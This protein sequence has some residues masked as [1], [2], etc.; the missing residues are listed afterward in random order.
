MAARYG[1]DNID[2]LRGDIL[3]LPKLGRSFDHAECVGVLYHMADPRAG[4]QAV[5]TVLRPGTFLRLGLYGESARA[6]GE[7]AK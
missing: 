5:S 2:F 1:I 4:L 6:G 7:G 3:D